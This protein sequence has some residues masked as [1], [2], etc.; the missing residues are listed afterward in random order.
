M[1]YE[2]KFWKKSYD[3]HVLELDPK[4]W[5]MT[6]PAAIRN[7][8]DNLPNKMAFTSLGTEFSYKQ[9]DLLSNQFA[10]MLIDNGFKTGDICGICLP[11]IP[12]Y[13]IAYVGTLKAGCAVSGVSPL[14]SPIQIQYQ[15]NDLGSDGK[16]V[17]LIALE[18]VYAK[19]IKKIQKEIPQLKIVITT[20]IRNFLNKSK[21]FLKK[22]IGK[23]PKKKVT[24]LS[25]IKVMNFHKELIG[26]YS[27]AL[28]SLK[29][30]PDDL[31]FIQYTGGTTGPPR[32]A[33]LTHRNFLSDIIIFQKWSNWDH[34]KGVIL[35]GFPFFHIAGIFTCA[36]M[37][38]LGWTQVLIPNPRDI[39]QICKEIKKYQPTVLANVPVLYQMLLREPMF[40]SL[41]HS[42]LEVIMSGAASFPK[43]SQ[44]IV[45]SVVGKGKLVDVY[46]MTET[47]PVTVAN[48]LL[49]TKKL[50]SIGLPLNNIEI[51][52]VDPES[53][54]EVPVGEPGE[55]CVKGPMVMKGYLNKPEETKV[56]ID[57]DGY[58]HTGDVAVMDKDGYLKIVDRVKDM[59]I[60]SGFKVFSAKVEDILVKHPSVKKIAIIGVPNPDRPGSELVKAF[61]QI[62]PSYTYD[63]NE[64]TLKADIIQF[65]KDNCS[66]YEV[67]KI[68][69]ITK[70]L[71][72]ISVGKIDK[73]VLRK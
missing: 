5:D 33:M 16:K 22:I 58:M 73:K 54:K 42:K 68:I 67:P 64:E 59:I 57:N 55:L 21:S 36:S 1:V 71:P 44:E 6:Y 53:N 25:G 62:D 26:Q 41:D 14:L 18:A 23:I 43:E 3:A 34:G 52:L 32:G 47:S 40:A 4:E 48:P 19:H 39:K 45:E 2:T 7:T 31:A 35:S 56:A 72:L 29:I 65:A 8:F 38:F 66:P 28:P 51:K 63:G 15:L 20:S 70:E 49:G 11:N 13:I 9:L 37:I 10:N 61:I 17:A 12:E 30:S 60:V 24:P 50:G 46:G 27:D 69:E